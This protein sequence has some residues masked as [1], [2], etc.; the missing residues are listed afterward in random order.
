MAASIFNGTAVKLLKDILRFKTG[1]EVVTGNSS[2][3]TSVA[4]NSPIG[5]LYIRSGTNEVYVKAD[6]GSST[7]WNRLT[8]TSDVQS[9][10]FIANSDRDAE[11]SVGNWVAYADAA[12]TS[13]VDMTGGSPNSTITRTTTAGAILNGVASFKLTKS[14]GAS[15]QGEGVSVSFTVPP[16]YQGKMCQIQFPYRVTSG[17]VTSQDFLVYLYDVTNSVLITPSSNDLVG[18]QGT[19]TCS[20]TTSQPAGTPANQTYRLGIHIASAT[21]STVNIS[22]DDVEVKPGIMVNTQVQTEWISAGA[23]TITGTTSNPTKG[24]TITVDKMEY[25]RV[26]NSAH[27]RGEYRQTAAGSAGS[28]DYLFAMPSGLLIDTTRTTVYTTVEGSGNYLLNSTL[29]SAAFG[30]TSNSR[31]GVGNIVPYSTTQFRIAGVMLNSGTNAGF[32]TFVC[33]AGECSLDLTNMYYT[34]DFIVPIQGWGTQDA[35]LPSQTD[36]GWTTANFTTSDFTGF[37]T[38]TAINVQH[39]RIGD[40][41]EIKGL[42]TAG[43]T[44]ATEARLNIPGGQTSASTIG[45]LE[46]AGQFLMGGNFA[47]SANTLV[48]ASKTYITFGLSGAS[49]TG[50]AKA[51]GNAFTTGQTFSLTA[52]VP[53]AGWSSNQR[54][55][56]LIG[57]VTSNSTGAERI[58]RAR[59]TNTGTPT[60]ASQSSSWISSITDNGVGDMTINITS[61]TFSAVPTVIATP[62]PNSDI[63]SVIQTYDFGTARTV[64]AVRIRTMKGDGTMT[65]M[66]VDVIVMGP[67]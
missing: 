8:N 67:R 14:S 15:R 44:T 29:G 32:G 62:G 38:V 10:N 51:N 65:D 64:T 20:F 56:T 17:T 47:G 7:N 33:S 48:E 22:F 31:N 34:F 49:N 42:F 26:G 55:P 1:T 12:A 25:R 4:V 46:C 52:K 59:I 11:I 39:R 13:P 19:M 27:I 18:T 63:T 61:G 2:D 36:Y 30:T 24:G 35:V 57:S 40:S 16:A 53:I 58:E 43:T 60:V 41:M 66:T 5:S 9:F 21:N 28:G 50:N 3:P 6:S 37:G 45:T 54:A 23:L